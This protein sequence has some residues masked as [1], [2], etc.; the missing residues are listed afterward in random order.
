MFGAA[1]KKSSPREYPGVGN[2]AAFILSPSKS[3]K[4]SKVG[5][6][7][8]LSATI[9]SNASHTTCETDSVDGPTILKSL[10]RSLPKGPR[11]PKTGDGNSYWLSTNDNVYLDRKTAVKGY[12]VVSYRKMKRGGKRVV[13]DILDGKPYYC[14]VGIQKRI[15]ENA[16]VFATKQEALSERFPSNQVN[17]FLHKDF[18]CADAVSLEN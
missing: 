13:F 14:G 11:I 4:G 17:V 16:V 9:A 5:V 1:K 2:L 12:R 6:E 8:Y 10:P 18:Y 7:D 15:T 3:P